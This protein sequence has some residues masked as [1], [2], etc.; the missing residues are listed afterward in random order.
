MR[1]SCFQRQFNLKIKYPYPSS[2]H[3]SASMHRLHRRRTFQPVSPMESVY[4]K[5]FV[6]VARKDFFPHAGVAVFICDW[7]QITT[8]F[9]HEPPFQHILIWLLSFPIPRNAGSCRESL[10]TGRAR[11]HLSKFM[12]ADVII[13][14][15]KE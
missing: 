4:R 6:R 14:S 9:S 10:E 3:C 13:F 11:M 7:Q 12:L 8:P 5:L 1:S 2:F 15:I